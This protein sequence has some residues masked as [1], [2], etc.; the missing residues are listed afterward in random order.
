MSQKE[1][2]KW[3]LWLK[4]SGGFVVGFVGFLM[5]SALFDDRFPDEGVKWVFLI[6]AGLCI[7]Y[8]IGLFRRW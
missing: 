4:L 5:W 1:R 7:T 2:K 8:V 6:G 3:P